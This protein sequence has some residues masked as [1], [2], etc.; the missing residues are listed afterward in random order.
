M[1]DGSVVD[2]YFVF[3]ANVKKGTAT[4][5]LTPTSQIHIAPTPR[6]GSPELLTLASSSRLRNGQ[7]TFCAHV[8]RFRLA[9]LPVGFEIPVDAGEIHI[10]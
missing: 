9:S 5:T 6:F 7:R 10:Y 8:P 1:G 4:M 3:H 2:R